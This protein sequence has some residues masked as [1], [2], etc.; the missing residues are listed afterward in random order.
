MFRYERR[1]QALAPP[2]VFYRRIVR[3]SV[4]GFVLILVSLLA[5]MAGY[6]GFEGLGFLDSFLNASMILAG[7]GPL[8]NPITPGGKVFAGLFAL[9]SGLAVLAIA[10]VI[11]APILHRLMHRFHLEEE[12]DA[13]GKGDKRDGKPRSKR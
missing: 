6:A 12:A 5:G 1:H 11:F 8:H 13:G 2:G 9:Y 3:S 4:V 7:M 10:A